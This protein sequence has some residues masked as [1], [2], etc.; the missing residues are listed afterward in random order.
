MPPRLYNMKHEVF[1]TSTQWCTMQYFFII[2]YRASKKDIL[3]EKGCPTI[4]I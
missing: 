1:G 2:F 3:E 4:S